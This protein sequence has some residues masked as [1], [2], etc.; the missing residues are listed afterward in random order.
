RDNFIKPMERF[1]DKTLLT[2]DMMAFLIETFVDSVHENFKPY[3]KRVFS[4]FHGSMN[5]REFRQHLIET[6]D[7]ERG[8]RYAGRG[9][10]SSDEIDGALFSMLPLTPTYELRER[11][12]NIFGKLPVST[13]V[14]ARTM[15]IYDQL[16]GVSG[17][18]SMVSSKGLQDIC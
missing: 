14:A 12:S 10:V 2:E 11:V 1:W 7:K 9:V 17:S 13:E 6:I 8:L 16:S 5:T 18:R 3:F 15:E 4:Q